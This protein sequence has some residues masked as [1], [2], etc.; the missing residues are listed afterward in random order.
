MRRRPP[1]STRT[2]TLFPYTTL[3]RSP[4]G[5]P[6]AEPVQPPA[7]EGD[8][9]TEQ[10]DKRAHDRDRAVARTD[11][12]SDAVAHRDADHGMAEVVAQRHASHRRDVPQPAMPAGAGEPAHEPRRI[13]R[14]EERRVGNVCGRTCRSRMSLTH[15]RKH[16]DTKSYVEQLPIT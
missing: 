11:S 6:E 16:T 2:D 4:F 1:R 10:H 14:A 3:C 12:Q 8:L 9:R 7:A 5:G 13:A 15:S